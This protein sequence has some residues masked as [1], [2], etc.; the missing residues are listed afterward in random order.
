MTKDT[1]D[2][3]TI[4]KATAADVPAIVELRHEMGLEPF[5]NILYTDLV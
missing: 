4:R 3:I 2:E 5:V 1:K